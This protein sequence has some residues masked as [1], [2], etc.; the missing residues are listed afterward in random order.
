MRKFC[1]RAHRWVGLLLAGF[2]C[3]AGLTG[4]LLVWNDELDAAINPAIF[5]ADRPAADSQPID[6]LALRARLAERYPNAFVNYV[7]LH[8]EPGRITRFLLQSRPPVAGQRVP[9]ANDQVMINP[10][11]GVVQGERRWGDITQGKKN[12]MPFIYRLH[13]SLAL[14][15]VGTYTFGIVSLLWTLDCFVGAYLTF[16]ARVRRLVGHRTGRQWLARWRSAWGIRWRASGYKLNFDLHRAGGLWTWV[17]LF[18]LAWSSVA[19]NLHEVYSPVMRAIFPHQVDRVEERIRGKP[20]GEPGLNWVEARETGR[21][22]MAEQAGA[23]GFAIFREHALY[24][25]ARRVLFRYDVLSSLDIRERSGKTSL[26]FDA[27]TGA[28]RLLWLPTGGASGDTARMWLTSLH[29]AALWGMPFKLFMTAMG[30]VV[31]MLSVTGL[32]IWARKRRS[33][34]DRLRRKGMDPA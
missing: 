26:W 25:D 24:Y 4:S 22:L 18:V 11:T 17:M 9:L 12:I 8:I 20:Q 1:V 28:M 34:R 14:G 30:M 6:P 29:M 33:K 19:F 16:P 21:R 23:R 10:Y 5:Q 15:I 27:N 31:A 32:V 3:V 7:P 13:D 2:L